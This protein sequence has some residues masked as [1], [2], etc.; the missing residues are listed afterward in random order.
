MSTVSFQGVT[1]AFAGTVAIDDLSIDIADGEFL[2]V[3]GPSGCGKSTALRLLAGLDTPDSGL[4]EIGGQTVN[5]VDARH[6]DVAMVFQSYALYPHMTVARNI[7]SPLV[8]RRIGDLDRAD[9]A[10]RVARAAAMLGLEGL[11]G[12]KPAQLSGG[13]RQRV[14]LARAIVREPAVF[15]MDEPLSNL[16]AE[17][18]ARTRSE[19]V[20]LH[21]RLDTTFVYVTHDQAEAMSM[22]TRIA[23]LDCGRLQQLGDPRAVYGSPANIFV[24]RFMG[25]PAMNLLSGT[26]D[27]ANELP[28]VHIAG[29]RVPIDASWQSLHHE[30]PVTVGVRPEHIHIG[31]VGIN[32]TLEAAEWLGHE[33]ILTVRVADSTIAVRAPEHFEGGG[34]GRPITVSCAPAAVHLFD[35]VSGRRLAQERS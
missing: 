2:V 11:L 22:A 24:A 9:R 19:L 35:P 7:E 14:A 32:A 12:R 10:E 20:D 8:G 31:A 3:L 34:S 4:I 6:R 33:Q 26:V 1:K 18:R 17:L 28:M 23:V 27:L 29:G 25:S 5:D 15:C 21:R 16:D 13:Q 30:Q